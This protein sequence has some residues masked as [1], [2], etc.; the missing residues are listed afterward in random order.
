MRNS[1][2]TGW[3]FL[4]VLG[5][6]RSLLYK[7]FQHPW[8]LWVS[9]FTPLTWTLHS[10][11]GWPV[12]PLTFL[13]LVS[14][15]GGGHHQKQQEKNCMGFK[16]LVVP[17]RWLYIVSNGTLVTTKLE[18]SII[19]MTIG[20]HPTLL[21]REE[22]SWE[23]GRPPLSSARDELILNHSFFSIIVIFGT[24]PN[25][26]GRSLGSSLCLE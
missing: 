25:S 17:F 9:N 1:L 13:H 3:N 14:Q 20:K 26:W 11:A 2:L 21:G 24:G 18:G 5:R 7:C 22:S 23:K 6:G 8:G 12:T 15:T 10:S 4:Q 19:S 16:S